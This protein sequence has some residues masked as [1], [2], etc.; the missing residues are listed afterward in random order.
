MILRN[1]YNIL[2]AVV[3]AAAAAAAAADDCGFSPALD[4][5]AQNVSSWYYYIHAMMMYN[6]I[7]YCLV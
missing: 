2:A 1:A 4:R 7:Y 5:R 6:I 3:A